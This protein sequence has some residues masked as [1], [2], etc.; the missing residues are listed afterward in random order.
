MG[1]LD[2]K[3]EILGHSAEDVAVECAEKMVHEDSSLIT[4]YYGSDVSEER[5]ARIGRRAGGGVIPTG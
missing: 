2:N 3:L 1:M 5:G 4:V